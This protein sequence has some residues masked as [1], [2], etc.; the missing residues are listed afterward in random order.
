MSSTFIIAPNTPSWTSM[1][2]FRNSLA[3]SSKIGFAMLLGAAAVNPGL[4]PLR[5]SAYRV[6]WL[7]SRTAPCISLSECSKLDS[8]CVALNTR[9]F[10]VL[11]TRYLM[12]ACSSSCVMPTRIINPRCICPVVLPSTV[13]FAWVT[14]CI[15]NL[16]ACYFLVILL[17]RRVG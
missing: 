8:P 4:R 6:N 10:T 12:S 7:T 3:T 2:V 16:I 1:P 11:L 9:I 14:R 15:T 5:V 17:L 13:T